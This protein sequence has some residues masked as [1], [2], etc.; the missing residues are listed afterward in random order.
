MGQAALKQGGGYPAPSSS[1]YLQAPNSGCHTT[2]SDCIGS[3]VTEKL[4]EASLGGGR[5]HLQSAAAPTLI[6]HPEAVKASQPPGPAFTWTLMLWAL[7]LLQGS[8]SERLTL[9]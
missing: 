8:T 4:F 2:H 7:T 9:S 6:Q 3:D 5:E 1:P